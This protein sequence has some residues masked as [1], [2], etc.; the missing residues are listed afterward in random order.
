[1]KHLEILESPCAYIKNETAV[2]FICNH[3][4]KLK[5]AKKYAE[6]KH[7]GIIHRI[8]NACYGNLISKQG[9]GTDNEE[10][11]AGHITDEVVDASASNALSRILESTDKFPMPNLT[12][13]E[14]EYICQ[15]ISPKVIRDYFQRYPKEFSK[16][17]PGFRVAS[18]SDDDTI[19]LVCKNI[20]KSFVSS[21]IEKRI[22]YWREEIHNYQKSLEQ[23]GDSAEKALL[24]TIPESVFHGNVALFFKIMEEAHSEEYVSLAEG[25]LQLLGEKASAED[26][27]DKESMHDE[28]TDQQGSENAVMKQKISELS[29]EILQLRRELEV[30]K[31]AHLEC[32]KEIFSLSGIREALEGDLSAAKTKIEEETMKASQ[33]QSELDRLHQRT[34]YADIDLEDEG[35]AE[36]KYTSVCQVYSDYSGKKWLNR[37]ADIKD[38]KIIWFTKM[39]EIPAFFGNRDKLIWKDGPE[40]EGFIGVWN[41]NAVPRNT[42]SAKDY[43]KVQYNSSVKC[44]EVVELAECYSYEDVSRYLTGNPIPNQ[45]G[46][47]T[48]FVYQTM[49]NQ[50]DGLLCGEWDFEIV[51]GIFRLK[52][53]V[54][55]LPQYTIYCSDILDIAGKKLY[56]YTSMGIPQG[57]FQVKSPLEV[58]KEIVVGRATSAYFRQRALTIKETQRCQTFLRELPKKTIYQEIVDAYGCT[59]AMAE[60]YLLAFIEQADSYLEKNDIDLAA[61]GAAVERNQNLVMT[62]KELLAED[63][64]RENAE[65]LQ[66]AQEELETVRKSA[67]EKKEVLNAL[68]ICYHKTQDELENIQAE[69]AS[70]KVLAQD[71]EEKVAARIVAAKE[72]AADFICEMAFAMPEY[73]RNV[74]ASHG[75]NDSALSVT[76]RRNKISVGEQITDIDSFEEELGDNLGLTGYDDFT[77]VQMAQVIV[78]SIAN[79]MPIVCGTNAERIAD[80]IAVMFGGEGANAISLP[81]GEPRCAEICELI[82]QEAESANKVFLVNGIFDGFSLNA[83]Y[84]MM[85]HSTEWN[86]NVVLVLPLNGI[87]TEMIS[88]SV[89]NRAMFIDGDVGIVNFAA[90]TLNA[91][92]TSVD[93]VIE[94]D[95]D[96]FYQKRRLLKLFSGMIDNTAILNYAKY[97]AI[98]NENLQS[99]GMIL[100][101]I[102]LNAKSAGK[103]EELLETLSSI[104]INPKVNERISKYL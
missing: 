21:L 53:S 67:N 45:Q 18:L 7:N 3:C 77:A 80:C 94:Y 6:Y 10:D 31:T 88:S 46:G 49:S 23:K 82:K 12:D 96:I 35:N 83:F 60:E 70:R 15:Q 64:Q 86:H 42:D 78:F 9:N 39:D 28:E 30:E 2:E 47:K 26:N 98:T 97:M 50:M 69:I 37:L 48:L 16:I 51:N 27:S 1:M 11:S 74:S 25:A 89:W 92:T 44:I 19:A 100:T 59:E 36:Y 62:C 57:I 55:T 68:E 5:I 75:K 34:K 81:I 43:I 38:G 95:K 52:K 63:W 56:R 84:E 24:K 32:E 22:N 4:N 93:F 13:E 91:F 61:L 17:R 90:D 54:Y 8:C 41:W 76:Y 65:Q 40:T 66:M 104:E 102:V 58:V 103:K 87:E 79:K 99:D 73:A 72:N 14:I 71:V 20:T 85:Q 33:I 29:V 101:Q